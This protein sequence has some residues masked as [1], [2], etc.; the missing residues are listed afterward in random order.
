[1][2]MIDVFGHLGIEPTKDKKQ[3]KRAYASIVKQYHPEEYP[4]EWKRVY[5]AYQEALRYAENG[6]YEVAFVTRGASLESTELETSQELMQVEKSLETTIPRESQELTDLRNLQEF[7]GHE[8]PQEV[9]AHEDLY[10]KLSKGET[11][12]RE[13]PDDQEEAPLLTATFKELDK[14]LQLI[15]IGNTVGAV[16]ILASEPFTHCYH[17]FDVLNRLN[18]NLNQVG[19]SSYAA[20]N[21]V[22]GLENLQEK[23]E[24][25]QQHS[26]A[27]F[28]KRIILGLKR[29]YEIY[30]YEEHQKKYKEELEGKCLR[31]CLRIWW[32]E[33]YYKDFWLGFIKDLI[34]VA[35]GL[36]ALLVIMFILLAIINFIVFF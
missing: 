19:L 35:L 10:E 26:Q 16:A 12:L 25:G 7:W 15:K 14:M 28:I 34:H 18:R 9:I 33:S 20:E 31:E 4:S 3:I 11:V 13:Q 17:N 6:F 8:E 36:I 22:T 5:Q 23:L 32:E 29:R 27:D 1:M 30:S 21:F 2:N 24:E